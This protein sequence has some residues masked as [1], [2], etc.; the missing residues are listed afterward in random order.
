MY[1]LYIDRWLSFSQLYS[2][3]FAASTM[4]SSLKD[5][6]KYAFELAKAAREMPV[7]KAEE[8]EHIKALRFRSQIKALKQ[9][10]NKKFR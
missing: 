1:H 5:I 9:R 6:H 10:L 4:D 7:S 3:R 2:Y 8:L